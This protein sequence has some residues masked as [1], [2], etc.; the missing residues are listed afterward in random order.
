M[1]L[2]DKVAIVTGATAGIGRAIAKKLASHGVKVACIGTNPERGLEVVKEIQNGA[3]FYPCN[4]ANTQEVDDTVKKI[5]DHFGRVDILV[6]NAGIT[7]DNLLLKMGEVDWDLVMATNVK[8]CYNFSKACIRTM[9][10]NRFGRIINISSVVGLTGNAG[11]VNYAASKAAVI[12][13]TKA[14]AKEIASRNILVNC[15]APGYIETQMTEA[16][17][18]AAKEVTMTQIPLGRMGRA[19]EIADAVVF[20]A[21]DYATYITGQVISV[22]GG[23][24]M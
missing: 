3:V 17:S 6:N 4:V 11:Q 22:D 21:S 20:L 1:N 5:I 23:M 8:S 18:D 19:D 7:R 12:G 24:A 2:N 10:K 9:M 15:I 14:L 16:M 13:L